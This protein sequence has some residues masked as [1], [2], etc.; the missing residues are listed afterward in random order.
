M[1][2][3]WWEIQILADPSLEEILFWRLDNFG[4]Q[5]MMSEAKENSQ[6]VQAYIPQ[7][8][9]QPLDLAALSLWIH[10]DAILM[11][12]TVPNISWSLMDDQ[13]WA[14][15]WKQY[16]HPQ[17]IGDRVL[18]CPAWESPSQQTERLVVRLD[19]G[20][21]FG[22]GI[23]PTTQLC[24][25]ALEMR[26]NYGYTGGILADL[27][28]G[29]G[30]LSITSLLMGADQVY[31][32]DTDP[33]AIQST[34]DNRELNHIPPETLVVEQGSIQKIAEI[35]PEGIDGIICNIIAETIIDLI[36]KF[37]AIAKPEAWGILSGVLMDKA[38]SVSDQLE[39]H[40]WKVGSLWRRKE[41]CCLNIRRQ[42]PDE[43]DD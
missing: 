17:E 30:I 12:I 40:G 34:Q 33:I 29:S 11:G 23:H 36:P 35:A 27:G 31:A 7:V 5:G 15:N 22:T 9:A 4:C 21:A 25:E 14:S 26:Y 42:T 6:L 8:Q 3:S 24:L 13:D 38:P 41:W 19:P 1:V 2:N 20:V 28:C 16:W 10:Q 39:K 43:L 37:N 18:I 32:V